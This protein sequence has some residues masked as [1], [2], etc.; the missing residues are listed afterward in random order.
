MKLVKT[1]DP[2]GTK[3]LHAWVGDPWKRIGDPD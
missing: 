2:E 1:E 3:F